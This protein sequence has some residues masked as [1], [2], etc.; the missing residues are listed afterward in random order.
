MPFPSA[1]TSVQHAGF[2]I[3]EFVLVLI[4]AASALAGTMMMLS[5]S[6]G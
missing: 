3:A 1:R 6:I 5:Y 4:L 2:D